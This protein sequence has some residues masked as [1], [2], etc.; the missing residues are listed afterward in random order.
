MVGAPDG[1]DFCFVAVGVVDVAVVG[2]VI[3]VVVIVGVVIGVV[4]FGHAMWFE[5]GPETVGVHCVNA[6]GAGEV[7]AVG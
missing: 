7:D 5:R 4:W 1:F 6:A 3:V 2:V